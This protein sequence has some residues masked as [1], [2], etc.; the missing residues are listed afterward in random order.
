MTWPSAVC[1][2]ASGCA[3]A[4]CGA[5]SDRCGA[6]C[7]PRPAGRRDPHLPADWPAVRA[8]KVFHSLAHR[9]EEPARAR[10]AEIL[11]VVAL[12]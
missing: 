12:N 5:G 3:H 1:S 6:A 11:D 8:E 4:C 2:A 7:G 9:Y 10:A